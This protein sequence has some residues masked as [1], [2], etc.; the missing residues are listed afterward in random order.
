MLKFEAGYGS[1]E[2]EL[3][4]PGT[5]EDCASAYYVNCQITLAPGVTVTPEI[6]VIDNE[7]KTVGGAVTEE[8]ETTYWGAKWMINF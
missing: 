6:G 2:T 1:L 4:R 8:G 7:D 3:D 5:Y